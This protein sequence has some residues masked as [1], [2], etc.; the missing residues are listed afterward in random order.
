QQP[1]RVST[2]GLARDRI[3]ARVSLQRPRTASPE[4]GGLHEPEQFFPQAPRRAFSRCREAGIR[5]VCP[6]DVETWGVYLM[7]GGSAK[8][9][10]ALPPRFFRFF[11]IVRL[12][13]GGRQVG[14]QGDSYH[15]R[16]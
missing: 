2:N 5:G 14:Q 6:W 13:A 4:R 11:P 16:S 3:A 15:L 1:G 9:D 7:A 8:G 12:S 10:I